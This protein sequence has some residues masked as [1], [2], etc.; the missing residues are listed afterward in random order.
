MPIQD[1][2]LNFYSKRKEFFFFF[3]KIS[4]YLEES[5]AIASFDVFHH[6]TQV[7]LRLETALETDDERVVGEAEDVAFGESLFDLVTQ[8]QVAFVD[9]LH[10]EPLARFA[11]AHQIDGPVGTVRYQLDHFVITL[12]GQM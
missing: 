9:L 11:V 6:H 4:V 3:F 2:Y 7:L 5:G 1:L 8:E 10:G 12:L